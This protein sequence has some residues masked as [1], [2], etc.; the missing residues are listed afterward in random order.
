M[1]NYTE[2]EVQEI[3]YRRFLGTGFS[4]EEANDVAEKYRD[5]AV[6][7]FKKGSSYDTIL[8]DLLTRILL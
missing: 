4:E 6:E 8:R 2:N 7:L 1:R 5:D 3:L